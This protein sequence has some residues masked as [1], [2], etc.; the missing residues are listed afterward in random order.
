MSS[1]SQDKQV[2]YFFGIY[3]NECGF[4]CWSRP[5][6]SFVAKDYREFACPNEKCSQFGDWFEVR[7]QVATSR[8]NDPSYRRGRIEGLDNME[9]D[10]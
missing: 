3:C 4:F 5:V 7:G 2:G 10:K 6:E 9:P 8:Y 1:T